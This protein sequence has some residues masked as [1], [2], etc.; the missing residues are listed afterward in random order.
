MNPIIPLVT[1]N[2]LLSFQTTKKKKKYNDEQSQTVINQNWI[3]V[4]TKAKISKS[5]ITETFICL[6]GSSGH[7]VDGS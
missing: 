7:S 6:T 1:E 4:D 3:S 5:K 2:Q